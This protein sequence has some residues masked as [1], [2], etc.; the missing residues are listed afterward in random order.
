[1]VRDNTL[2]V[3]IA[4][5]GSDNPAVKAAYVKQLQK[6]NFGKPPHTLIFPG[7]LHFME[8]EALVTLAKAPQGILEL[9]K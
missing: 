3:G 8:A 1:V 4:R 5:A 7:K 2:V 9:V 6:Y